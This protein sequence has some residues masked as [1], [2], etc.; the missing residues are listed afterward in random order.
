M[1]LDRASA[2]LTEKQRLPIV[3]IARLVGYAD[4]GY[5]ASE[6][7]KCFGAGPKAYAQTHRGAVPLRLDVA[8]GAP[9]AAGHRAVLNQ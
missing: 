2:L 3:E 7:R 4:T 5:F 1:R 8:A 6:F 9:V